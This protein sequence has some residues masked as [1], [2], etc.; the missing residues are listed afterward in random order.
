MSEHVELNPAPKG[1]G[2]SSFLYKTYVAYGPLSA[3]EY[4][5]NTCFQN[6]QDKISNIFGLKIRL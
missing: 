5:E 3:Y 2:F 1:T 6:E 4:R